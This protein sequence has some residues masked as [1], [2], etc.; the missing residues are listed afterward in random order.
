MVLARTALDRD[1]T[2]GAVDA[3]VSAMGEFDG[4]GDQEGK[5]EAVRL[6]QEAHRRRGQRI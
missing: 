4:L 5:A 3:L 2:D 1:D 6:V